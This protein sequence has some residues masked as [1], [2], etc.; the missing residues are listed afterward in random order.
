MSYR[1][2]FAIICIIS[3]CALLF[4]CPKANDSPL[5]NLNSEITAS[6]AK[7]AL[8]TGMPFA[9]ILKLTASAPTLLKNGSFHFILKDGDLWTRNEIAQDGVERIV[10]WEI[11][12]EGHD[13]N[14]VS[15]S[16]IDTLK[17][18]K[19]KNPWSLHFETNAPIGALKSYGSRVTLHVD[20]YNELNAF[21]ELEDLDGKSDK[22]SMLLI[23]GNRLLIK[24][25][26]PD[27]LS[28]AQ[29]LDINSIYMSALCFFLGNAFPNGPEEVKKTENKDFGGKDKPLKFNLAFGRKYVLPA[30]WTLSGQIEPNK[31][32]K[33]FDFAIKFQ[34]A[35]GSSSFK[36]SFM[37]P[38]KELS[39]EMPLSDW[40]LFKLSSDGLAAIEDRPK[41]LKE[42]RGK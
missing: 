40:S 12:T 32:P 8:K 15:E 28:P 33:S 24:G 6:Q 25:K 17:N 42:L 10:F 1:H 14:K 13:G 38:E 11:Q 36:G 21:S 23:D 16:S 37:Y 27:G 5:K 34:T 22:I 2:P 18:A 39:D 9:D 4:A 26:F 3:I 35:H 7:C 20:S 31:S 41:T 30:P 29:L 19:L